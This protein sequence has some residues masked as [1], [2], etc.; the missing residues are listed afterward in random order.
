MV[1]LSPGMTPKSNF[2]NFSQLLIKSCGESPAEIENWD[3]FSPC[4]HI[5]SPLRAPLAPVLQEGFES[6][7]RSGPSTW[8]G[9][10]P[11]PGSTPNREELGRGKGRD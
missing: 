2:V 6:R 3:L 1:C 11:H 9:C 7:V 5:T 4:C 8:D 10:D